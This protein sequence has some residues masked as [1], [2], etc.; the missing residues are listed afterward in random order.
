MNESTRQE[1]EKKHGFN[2][3]FLENTSKVV[4]SLI[5]RPEKS[6]VNKTFRD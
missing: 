6:A 1:N 3:S 5:E 2:S 4:D